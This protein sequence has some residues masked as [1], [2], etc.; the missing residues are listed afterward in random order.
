MQRLTHGRID[1]KERL[2]AI[3]FAL[4]YPSNQDNFFSK[5]TTGFQVLK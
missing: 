3:A 5:F 2:V 1:P 4:H